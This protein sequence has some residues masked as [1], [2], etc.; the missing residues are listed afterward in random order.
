[1]AI[2]AANENQDKALIG[3]TDDF[4]RVEGRRPR[5]LVALTKSELSSQFNEVSSSLAD[6]GFDVD[7]SPRFQSS[8]SLAKQAV[9]NDVHVL[10]VLVNKS[11]VDEMIDAIKTLKKKYKKLKKKK[12]SLKERESRLASKRAQLKA[13]Q[14]ASK[15]KLEAKN[16]RIAEL[17]AKIAEMAEDMCDDSSDSSDSSDVSS[18]DSD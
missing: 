15:A 18:S 5:V 12:K 11:F 3:L 14:A 4:A 17:K 8:E 6:L 13:H 2:Y 16:A 10:L 9:E 7:I 1:M